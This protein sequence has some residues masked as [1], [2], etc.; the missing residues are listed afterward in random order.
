MNRVRVHCLLEGYSQSV[1][2]LKKG[3]L[4]KRGEFVHTPLDH[5]IS[6]RGHS[7]EEIPPFMDFLRKML[8]LDPDERWDASKLLTHPWIADP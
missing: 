4:L 5:W 1:S 2:F 8:I 6:E 3:R 7:Q